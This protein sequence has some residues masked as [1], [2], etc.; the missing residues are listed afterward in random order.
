MKL[1]HNFKAMR[2][3]NLLILFLT[4]GKTYFK[5]VLYTKHN[6]IV[7]VFVF[8]NRIYVTISHLGIYAIPRFYSISILDSIQFN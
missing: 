1:Y 8:E 5:I 3:C 6:K 7:L 4:N 2:I